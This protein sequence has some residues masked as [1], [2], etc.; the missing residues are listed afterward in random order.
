MTDQPNAI[1][2]VTRHGTVGEATFVAQSRSLDASA[3]S[4]SDDAPTCAACGKPIRQDDIVC[5]HCGT[6]LVAG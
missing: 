5:P 6:P 4:A 1:E 2:P 3:P